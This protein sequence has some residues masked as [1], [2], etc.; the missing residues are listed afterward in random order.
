MS[1]GE[2]AATARRAVVLVAAAHLAVLAFMLAVTA[3]L[4]GSG[5]LLAVA[6]SGLERWDAVHYLRIAREGYA[7]PQ[8]AVFLPMYPLLV[9]A[10]TALLRN[11][12]LAALT[13]TL[14]AH[15]GG[16]WCL[17]RLLSLDHP[18]E[19]VERAI[20][21]LAVFPAALFAVAPYS[22][23]AFLLF[24]ASA[25]LCFRT[26]R[27]V[28]AGILAFLAVC[29]RLP[30]LALVAAMAAEYMTSMRREVK[31]RAMLF[32]LGFPLLGVGAYL[33]LN[34]RLFGHPLF[35]L[36]VQDR[37]FNRA[38]AWPWPAAASAL[39]MSWL[40]TWPSNLAQ[41]FD[42]VAGVA[43]ACAATVY[44]FRRMR[45]GD[46]VYCLAATLMFTCSTFWLSNLRY[47]YVLYP[48]YVMAAQ[49][50]RRA[51]VRV[52]LVAVSL[53]WL[54]ILSMQFARGHWVG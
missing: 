52:A 27:M 33:L 49:A 6:K 18:T 30:G 24:V 51:H 31:P 16:A 5:A 20:L 53:L 2:A 4:R 17:A 32:P 13:V 9:R 19:A 7:D 48:I 12:T 44:A 35:F 22:E 14:L 47:A 39:R 1:S 25:L 36:H 26:R 42:E 37:S 28:P 29:T 46:G 11:P 15:L 8:L 23:S 45:V 41:G 3:L 40:G 54:A 38:F 43:L 21:F 10:A 34:A 50:A